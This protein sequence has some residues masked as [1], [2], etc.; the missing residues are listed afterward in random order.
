TGA[1]M[2]DVDYKTDL[3]LCNRVVGDKAVIRGTLD[4]SSVLRFGNAQLVDDLSRKNIEALGRTGRFFL[5]GGCGIAPRT[6]P[7]N[8]RTMVEAARKYK[9]L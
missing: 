3:Q 9:S 1:D 2:L 6:P 4:P 5:A 8:I 7:D